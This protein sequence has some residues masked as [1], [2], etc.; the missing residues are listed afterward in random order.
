MNVSPNMNAKLT[1]AKLGR[2]DPCACGSGKKFKKC[3]GQQDLRGTAA[4]VLRAPAPPDVSPLL[5]MFKSGR[6]ADLEAATAALLERHP[7]AGALWKLSGA[8][9]WMQGKDALHAM[10]RAAQLL[11]DDAEAHGN[12]GNVLRAQRRLDEAEAS[13]RRA[14]E[15]KPDYAEAHNNLGSV[16]RDLGRFEEAVASYRR[17]LAIKPDFA[18][19]HDN[20]GLVLQSLGRFDQALSSHRRALVMNPD[21]AP[22]HSHLGDAL[23]GLGRLEEAVASY[24]RALA[25]RPSFAEAHGHLGNALLNLGRLDDALASCRRALEINPAD[26]E[27]HID[28]GNALSR[29][30]RPDEAVASYRR[31]LALQPDNADAHNN[32]GSVLWDLGMLEDALAS[33]RQALARKPD[34]AEVHNNLGNVLLDLGQ[35]EAAVQSYGRAIEL[36]PGYAKAHSNLGSAYR[37]WGQLDDAESSYRQALALEPDTAEVLANLGA[38]LRIQGRWDEAEASCG[39][40]MEINPTS[41]NVLISLAELHADKGRFTEA[42]ELY[43]RAI[44]VEPDSPYAWAG[45]ARARKMT[46]GD[47]A[48]IEKAERIATL[49]L[50]SREEVNL[51]YAM[52]K[53]YDDVRNF[54]SAFGN[55]RRAND[56]KKSARAPHDRA[57]VSR[58]FEAITRFYSREWVNQGRPVANPSLRPIFILGM[59]R[60]GTSL[61]EQILASHPAVF[62][63]G[64]LRFWTGAQARVA[65]ADLHADDVDGVLAELADEYLRLLDGL[66]VDAARVID[67]MPGNFLL[68][69]LIRAVFPNARIVHMRRSPI[70]TC[71]SIY[72]NNF[73]QAHTYTNDLEDLAHYYGEYLRVMD[74]WRS[75]LPPEALLDVPYEGLVEGQEEWSRK[76]IAFIGLPWDAA[77]LEF[78][79]TSRSVHTFSRWQVRQKITKAS[80]E[81]WRNYAQFL[82]PL[83]PLDESAA[84]P[85]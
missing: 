40:A 61:A 43:Q 19:A 10:T 55:Y 4:P 21:F 78:H 68:I 69:G 33:F 49:P 77:C 52:G 80:V 11:P 24:G 9:L 25:L 83:L 81:R 75:I 85:T 27:A 57:A 37:E 12:L 32:L 7:D 74:H 2:N 41:P 20:L 17:A 82:G 48:W 42:L 16:M 58:A 39:R 14:L 5:A 35:L 6:Y 44:A 60:S 31:A 45:M 66:S 30:G 51:R 22:A 13:H 71:L 79:R 72:F 53:Y 18:M 63:A 15:V 3:C 67:K 59:P 56:L 26:A 46:A 64:E 84:P 54:E 8:A 34:Y 29:L 65:S 36:K 47:T 70:D 76:M 23:R 73:Q 1:N 38:I 62:G 50:L 28:L